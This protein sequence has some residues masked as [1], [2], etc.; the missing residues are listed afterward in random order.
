MYNWYNLYHHFIGCANGKC[1]IT[2]NQTITIIYGALTGALFLN[3]F[4][5]QEKKSANLK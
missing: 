3:L 2:S 1:F 4:K 5:K